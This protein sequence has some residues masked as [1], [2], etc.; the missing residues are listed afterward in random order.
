MKKLTSGHTLQQGPREHSS[1][2]T[3]T[4]KLLHDRPE[5]G[6]GQS[7]NWRIFIYPVVAK[8]GYCWI[9]VQRIEPRVNFKNILFNL[10]GM[11]RDSMYKFYSG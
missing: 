11:G 4:P 7:G 10:L 6:G 1:C 2:Q 3:L 5:V 9:Q 8:I